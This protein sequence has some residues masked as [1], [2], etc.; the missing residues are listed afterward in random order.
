MR[1][2]SASSTVRC[3]TSSTRVTDR[4]VTVAVY[5]EFGRRVA[6]N[7]S[8]GT[9]HGHGGSILLAGHVRAGHHGEPPPLDALDDGDLATTIDFRA[10]LGG[11][12]EGVVGID[13]ADILGRG[14]A[15]LTLV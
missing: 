7:A 12:L 6:P 2:S 1:R 11:L 8:G 10:V 9:D 14:P 5:S 4:P 13:A 3:T 15:P